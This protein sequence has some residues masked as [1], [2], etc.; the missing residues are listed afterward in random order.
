MSATSKGSN[1]KRMHHFVSRFLLRNFTA[2]G[3]TLGIYNHSINKYYSVA[4][5]RQFAEWDLNTL[6]KKDKTPEYNFIENLFNEAFEKSAAKSIK[7]ILDFLAIPS[8]PFTLTDEDYYSIFR[9]VVFTHLRTPFIRNKVQHAILLNVYGAWYVDQFLKHGNFEQDSLFRKNRFLGLD[10]ALSFQYLLDF[11]NLIHHTLSDLKLT[12]LYHDY[13]DEYFLIPDQG[14]I[15][16]TESI[17][18]FAA[19]DLKIFLPL[20]SHVL[21]CYERITRSEKTN[22]RFINREQI[23]QH[24]RFV[25]QR[26]YDFIGCYNIDYLKAFVTENKDA[27]R[28]MKKYDPLKMKNDVQKIQKEV[29]E[30]LENRNFDKEIQMHINEENEFKILWVK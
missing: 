18:L 8:L 15:V 22:I 3:K 29:K 12:I 28:P 23:R 6:I 1:N 25:C 13:E 26:F 16:F 2:N 4:I 24:N 20:S 27:I 30:K 7:S 11:D 21:F 14:T 19:K 9:F 17:G 5:D 10:K